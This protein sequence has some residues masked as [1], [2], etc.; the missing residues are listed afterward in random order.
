MPEGRIQFISVYKDQVGCDGK[1]HTWDE[2]EALELEPVDQMIVSVFYISRKEE[3]DEFMARMARVH[4]KIKFTPRA[5]PRITRRVVAPP[6]EPEAQWVCPECGE[7]W[8]VSAVE[9]GWRESGTCA[10]CT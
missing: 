9:D 2:F 1:I 7:S 6:A 8:P 10:T 5:A 3:L 4:E